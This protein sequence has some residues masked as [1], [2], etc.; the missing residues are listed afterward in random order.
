MAS[1]RIELFFNACQILITKP[2][3][4][5]IISEIS[6]LCIWLHKHQNE[7][8]SDQWKAKLI[9]IIEKY[10]L[11]YKNNKNTNDNNNN[12]LLRL[13]EMVDKLLSDY[14]ALPEGKLVTGKFK[15]KVM[16]WQ[17]SL[18]HLN[19]NN[20]SHNIDNLNNSNVE[21]WIV[22]DV[23]DD[24]ITLMKPDCNNGDLIDVVINDAD[25]LKLIND[26]YNQEENSI[27]KY[28]QV[29]FDKANNL[30]LKLYDENGIGL[31]M[32]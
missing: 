32:K 9:L 25:M 10:H 11:Y 27:D 5:K 12:E 24:K 1:D 19:S 21:R 29:D 15:H 23:S 28:I 16:N 31:L 30:I 20:S 7:E 4:N 26:I 14:L 22:C 2:N 6:K 18:Q 3:I 13:E 17:T 8:I